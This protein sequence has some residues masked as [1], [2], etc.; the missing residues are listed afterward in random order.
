[1][2]QNIITQAINAIIFYKKLFYHSKFLMK[3]KAAGIKYT[4]KSG[5]YMIE[6]VRYI[7]SLQGWYK[8]RLVYSLERER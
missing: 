3:D 6:S 4:V 5:T 7:F 2:T 8:R 1:M